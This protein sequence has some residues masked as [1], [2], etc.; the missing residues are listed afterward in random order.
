MRVPEVRPEDEQ[1]VEQ[2]LDV[3]H[4][5]FSLGVDLQHPSMFL[6][7]KHKAALSSTSTVKGRRDFQLLGPDYE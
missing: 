7:R 6:H 4:Q 1:P 5:A 2:R 3:G